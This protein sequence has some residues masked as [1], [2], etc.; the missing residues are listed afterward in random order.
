M[1]IPSATNN[2]TKTQP[3]NPSS[4]P[5]GGQGT[6]HPGQPSGSQTFK[7]RQGTGKRKRNRHSRGGKGKPTGNTSR[8]K[9]N[10]KPK[11]VRRGPE[12]EYVSACCKA[13]AL[14][15]RCGQRVQLKD[16]ES[17]KMK[18]GYK[19]LGHWKC[20]NCRRGCKVSPQKPKEVTVANT[21]DASTG[22]SVVAA[23]N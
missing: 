6:S 4:S 9:G 17:G 11:A 5:K 3:S 23:S 21:G 15:P 2:T 16:P 12:F 7:P 19:G 8:N 1:Y 20:P 13:R 22:N 14:K 18:D 10:N